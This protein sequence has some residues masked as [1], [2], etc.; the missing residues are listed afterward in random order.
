MKGGTMMKKIDRKNL[1]ALVCFCIIAVLS[2][3]M[4]A[5]YLFFGHGKEVSAEE[6][7]YL[8]EQSEKYSG[9]LKAVYPGIPSD[10]YYDP[11]SEVVYKYTYS[12]ITDER[13]HSA[14]E[15]YY[16]DNLLHYCSHELTDNFV[17]FYIIQDGE[18]ITVTPDVNKCP[19]TT[20]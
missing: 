3:I 18:Y 2:I 11:V 7:T 6:N 10:L 17:T 20:K 15:M 4:V 16:G 13:R 1:P 19:R 12:N 14:T 8:I 9:K 5:Q